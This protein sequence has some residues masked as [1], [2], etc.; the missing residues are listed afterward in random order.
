M[1]H[2]LRWHL[3]VLSLVKAG[4]HA[5][6]YEDA[7][8]H[9]AFLDGSSLCVA[10]ADGAAGGFESR[11]W[12]KALADAFAQHPVAPDK[13]SVK[14][15]LQHPAQGWS[16]AIHWDRLQWYHQ[17]KAREGAFATFLGVVF[18]ADQWHALAVGDVCLF[19]VGQDELL[20]SF[21]IHGAKEFDTSP[22]LLSTKERYN[23][24]T[25]EFLTTENDTYSDSDAFFLMTDALAHWF[26]M[27]VESG[28]TPWRELDD[29][30]ADSFPLWIE[31]LRDQKLLRNDDVTLV[32]C[33]LRVELDDQTFPDEVN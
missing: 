17:A 31:A 32:R 5:T 13:E 19:Q 26:L 21:P 15:W 22:P 23:E 14:E 16:N 3:D 11:L 4:N 28:H 8:S 27:E 24:R 25:L 12:A 1:A 18:D 20:A 29:L 2:P 9:D 30:N 33:R 6:D 10:V 7:A